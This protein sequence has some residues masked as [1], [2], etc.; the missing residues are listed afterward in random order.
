MSLTVCGTLSSSGEEQ[1]LVAYS[2][3]QPSPTD[4]LMTSGALPA[5][6]ALFRSSLNVAWWS[7]QFDLD[8]RI[9]R[10]EA[11]DGVLDVLVERRRQVE[12][13]EGISAFGSTFGM[14]ASAGSAASAVAAADAAVLGLAAS[15]AAAL[16]DTAAVD[17]VVALL[18]ATDGDP[19][20]QPTA[21][22]I[23]AARIV[24]VRFSCTGVLLLGSRS[25]CCGGR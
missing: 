19:D 13:P 2:L 8:A 7:S 14:T 22:S 15:E 24:S 25:I 10:L 5:A 6:N 4:R 3:T 16:G 21:T 11:G 1:A 12:R 9:R 18:G 23:V 20:V 17:G